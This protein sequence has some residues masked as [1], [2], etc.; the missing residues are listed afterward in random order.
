MKPAA[1][2]GSGLRSQRKLA[3][4]P[5]PPPPAERCELCS[6]R[7]EEGHAHLV[8]PAAR[9]LRCACGACSFL[10]SGRAG[11]R[12]LRVPH[13][14]ELLRELSITDAQW[15]ELRLPI[16][17]AFFFRSSAAGRVVAF[18]PGPAGATE[19]LV[20]LEAWD[21][22]VSGNPALAGLQPDIEAL[23]VDRRGNARDSFLVSIDECYRLVGLIRTHWRGLS[24]G[25]QVQEELARFFAGLKGTADA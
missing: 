4:E 22:I 1:G 2:A 25:A 14:K 19:S 15:D 9:E 17:L 24:G 6:A 23:L 5:S 3:R 21:A 13:R 18:Y 20:S 8:D 16:E 12:W 11:S 7:I 10:L